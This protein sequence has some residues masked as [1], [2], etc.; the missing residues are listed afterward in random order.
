MSAQTAAPWQRLAIAGVD[1]AGRIIHVQDQLTLRRP[2]EQDGLVEI[3]I[4]GEVNHV[5]LLADEAV[6][7]VTV[8]Q[9]EQ[10]ELAACIVPLMGTI[11]G[12]AR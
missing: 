3:T 9:G 10:W 5:A 12:G 7:V 11:E 1:D 8:R 4:G 6:I 2:A